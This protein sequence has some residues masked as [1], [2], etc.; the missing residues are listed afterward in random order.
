M[1]EF[2]FFLPGEIPPVGEVLLEYTQIVLVP[3]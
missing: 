3:L 2:E 1:D